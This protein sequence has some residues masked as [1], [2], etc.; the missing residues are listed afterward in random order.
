MFTLLLTHGCHYITAH[1]AER[2]A[3][4]MRAGDDEL[5]VTSHISAMENMP[6]VTRIR[7]HQ[8]LKLIA[9]DIQ[10]PRSARPAWLSERRP[11]LRRTAGA[12]D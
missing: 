2:V 5:D 3:R 4:A 8:V 9:H 12:R 6:S 10:L 11:T 7:T 1:D